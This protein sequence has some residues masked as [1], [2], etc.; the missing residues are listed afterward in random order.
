M[1]QSIE[2]RTHTV[3]E[4]VRE[5]KTLLTMYGVMTLAIS[6]I[7]TFS[8]WRIEAERPA[9]DAQATATAVALEA[10]RRATLDQL[11]FTRGVNLDYISGTNQVLIRLNDSA[12]AAVSR[13]DV[14]S[15]AL[16]R[17]AMETNCDRLGP[18]TYLPGNPNRT[19]PENE[20]YS[21]TTQC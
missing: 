3:R 4:F 18:V 1:I 19:P 7:F 16:T 17:I 20:A 14:L 10:Q 15:R 2:G 5:N 6:G 9:R 12:K 13:E 21:V 8:Y 11:E